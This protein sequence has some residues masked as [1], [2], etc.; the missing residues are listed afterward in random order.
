[1]SYNID[2]ATLLF[3]NYSLQE[4]DTGFVWIDGRHIY[5]KTVDTGTL[6]NTTTKTIAHNISDF[7]RTVRPPEGW[8]YRDSDK[9][10]INVPFIGVN[11]KCQVTVNRTNIVYATDANMQD[12]I[13][14]YM[15]LYYLK[16]S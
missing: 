8:A 2:F 16:T 3:G 11:G 15:T 14:S 7:D 6:P 13:N 5:K 10:T 9:T 1:M 4:V 12:F